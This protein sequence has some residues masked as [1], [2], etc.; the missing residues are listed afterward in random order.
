M[1]PV[2]T[3]QTPSGTATITR[4]GS[5]FT[6]GIGSASSGQRAVRQYG[7]RSPVTGAPQV[8]QRTVSIDVDASAPSCLAHLI[9]RAGRMAGCR[10]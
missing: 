6:S 10:S 8:W 7:Q 4:S 1:K 3:S 2:G 5:I 9:G